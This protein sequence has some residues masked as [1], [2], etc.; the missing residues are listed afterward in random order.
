M[1]ERD[2]FLR[3]L[4]TTE[5]SALD[6]AGIVRTFPAG[7]P[8]VREGDLTDHVLIL[9]RGYVKAV[10]AT[11]TG[12]QSILGFRGPGDIVGELA[13]LHHHPRRATLVAI[14]TVEALILPG[15]RFRQLLARHPAIPLALARSLAARLVEADRY[16]PA[17][18]LVGVGPALAQLILDLALRYGTRTADGGWSL[19]VRLRQRDLAD[20]LAVSSRSIA[21]ALDLWRRRGLVTTGRQSI[22][23]RRPDLLRSITEPPRHR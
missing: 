16:R 15:H 21:R 5:Q 2:A 3:A 8:L 10:V 13:G 12:G 19:G 14:D 7:T 9:R 20:R 6:A 4:P 17:V 1:D 22:V 11:P 18:S 23:V